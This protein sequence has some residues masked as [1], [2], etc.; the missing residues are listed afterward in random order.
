MD[1]TAIGFGVTLQLEQ[2][3]QGGSVNF[4]SDKWLGKGTPS[5]HDIQAIVDDFLIYENRGFTKSGAIATSDDQVDFEATAKK[6]EGAARRLGALG[7]GTQIDEDGTLAVGIREGSANTRALTA[8]KLI[9]QLHRAKERE[10]GITILKTYQW[11]PGE[12]VFKG[13]AD[14]PDTLF[15]QVGGPPAEVE[16]ARKAKARDKGEFARGAAEA[17]LG[18]IAENIR[19]A[20]ARDPLIQ[21]AKRARETVGGLLGGFFNPQEQR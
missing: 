18:A 15:P 1:E 8:I 13:F 12:T 10:K 11:K 3:A 19:A 16:S 4:F 7:V 14:S 9:A 6:R 2:I 21:G 5:S 17:Q 20:N